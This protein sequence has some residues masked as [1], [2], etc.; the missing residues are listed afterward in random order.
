M[1]AWPWIALAAGGVF[2]VATATA[3]ISVCRWT[4]RMRAEGDCLAARP[5]A[6][7][8]NPADR[9]PAPGSRSYRAPGGEGLGTCYLTIHHHENGTVVLNHVLRTRRVLPAESDAAFFARL[10]RELGQP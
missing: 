1:T 10:E 2:W 7:G 6:P 5:P 8:R 3:A 4:A 9:A